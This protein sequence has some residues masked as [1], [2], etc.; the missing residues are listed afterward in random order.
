MQT[1][2]FQSNESTSSFKFIP[3]IL[4]LVGTLV[5]YILVSSLI[6]RNS[7]R[8]IVQEVEIPTVEEIRIIE[9]YSGHAWQQH[10]A[11]VNTAFRCLQDKGSTKSFKTFG[12]KDASGSN[13]PTSVFLCFDGVDWY[14]V[15]TTAFQKVGADKIA[16]LVTAYKVSKD[17]FPKIENYIDYIA[18]NWNAVE[19]KYVI[20]AGQ[21][22]LQPK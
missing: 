3:F 7:G 2:T 16:R 11:E 5:V 18:R 1:T 9:I 22:L 14:A 19:I 15:V 13:I 4:V 17:L 6:G 8:S 12:F 20:E 10:G 21:I